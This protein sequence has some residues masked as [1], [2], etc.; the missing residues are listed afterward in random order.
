MKFTM[1]HIATVAT[2]AALV[3][4]A[5]AGPLATGTPVDSATIR[6]AVSVGDL[7]LSTEAGRSVAAIRVTRTIRH[8]C[9]QLADDRRADFWASYTDCSREARALA[10]RQ[11]DARMLA[12]AKPTPG[13]ILSVR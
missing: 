6:A 3:G 11:L 8:L 2:L 13:A 12:A 1:T 10:Q 7:D 9:S 4:C 5:H